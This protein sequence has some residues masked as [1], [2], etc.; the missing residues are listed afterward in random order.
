VAETVAGWR[1]DRGE[2]DSLLR[3]FPPRYENVV[4]DHVTY[5]RVPRS[6][7][8]SHERAVLIGRVDDG[9]GVEAMVVQL[10]GSHERPTGG[11]YHITWSL[12]P[13]REAVESNAAI[14]AHGWQPLEETAGVGI[15]P[16][17]WP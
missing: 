12:G 14:A 2:R 1:I 7:L 4:A 17:S 11:T 13:G 5:G 8:P 16:A 10:G 15:E 3:R 6:E 9:A